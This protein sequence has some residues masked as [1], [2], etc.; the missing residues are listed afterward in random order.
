MSLR[1]KILIFAYAVDR[2]DV[3][4]SQMAYEWISRLSRWVDLIVV[5]TGSR[6]HPFCGLEE[7]EGVQLEIVRPPR[8]FS[9]VGRV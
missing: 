9:L 1:P 5:T 2:Q 8:I 3:S 6:I 4:E 7:M